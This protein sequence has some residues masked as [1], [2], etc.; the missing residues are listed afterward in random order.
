MKKNILSIAELRDLIHQG[1]ASDPLVFLE[2][3]MNGQDPREQSHIYKLACEIDEYCTDD[4]ISREDWDEIFDHITTYHKYQK[5][6]ITESI[7]AGKTLAEYLHAKRKQ[8]DIGA[9]NGDG[10]IV[11]SPLTEEEIVLF[12]ERFNDEY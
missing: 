5:V 1:K 6:S 8:I 10:S 11:D 7:N 9:S 12:R 4:G 3:I 2:S